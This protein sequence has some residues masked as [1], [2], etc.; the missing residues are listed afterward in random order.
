M[1]TSQLEATTRVLI[2]T[3]LENLGWELDGISKKPNVFL[4]NLVLRLNEKNWEE[5]VPIMFCTQSS[6]KTLNHLWLSSKL[7]KKVNA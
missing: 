5:N 1:K 4:N 6:I 3:S 2:N 7:R